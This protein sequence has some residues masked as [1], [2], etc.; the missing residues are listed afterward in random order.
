[1][2]GVFLVGVF[3]GVP[4]VFTLIFLAKISLMEDAF[5]D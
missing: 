1:M 2:F 4:F 3:I 5:L